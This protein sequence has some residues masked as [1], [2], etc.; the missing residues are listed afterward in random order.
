MQ[1][2]TPTERQAVDEARTDARSLQV[3]TAVDPGKV[4]T[5]PG[6]SRVSDLPTPVVVLLVLLLAAALAL[7]ASRIRTLVVARRG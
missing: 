3:G 7:G 6:V 2:A 4:G 5:V 1:A